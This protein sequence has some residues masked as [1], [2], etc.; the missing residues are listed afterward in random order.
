MIEMIAE[1]KIAEIVEVVND[2]YICPKTPSNLA[3]E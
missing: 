2:I 3:L 1:W